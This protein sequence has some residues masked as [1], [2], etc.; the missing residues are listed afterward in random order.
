MLWNLIVTFWTTSVYPNIENDI[1][2]SVFNVRKYS[3]YFSAPLWSHKRR[4]L[5]FKAGKKVDVST[6]LILLHN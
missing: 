1:T 5:K 4:Y 6:R 3:K 2:Q